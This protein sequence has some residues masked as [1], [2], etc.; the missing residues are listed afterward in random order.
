MNTRFSI[1]FV[2][3]LSS[4]AT[5]PYSWEGDYYER[6]MVEKCK[7]YRAEDAAGCHQYVDQIFYVSREDGF[8]RR[9]LSEATNFCMS[10]YGEADIDKQQLCIRENRRLVWTAYIDGIFR[11]K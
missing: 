8:L 11:K 3:L 6:V 10:K 9:K 4:C 7:V 1:F 5:D 2:A